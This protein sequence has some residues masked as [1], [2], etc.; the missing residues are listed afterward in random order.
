MDG[1]RNATTPYLK[2]Y[3]KNVCQL[4]IRPWILF[5]DSR[6]MRT[7]HFNFLFFSSEG[8]HSVLG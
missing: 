8:P 4:T 2:N 3:K 7:W 5:P 1:A 6:N